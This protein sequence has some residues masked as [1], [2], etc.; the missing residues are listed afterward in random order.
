MQLHRFGRLWGV[1]TIRHWKVLVFM[2]KELLWRE[3][4]DNRKSIE[5]IARCSFLEEEI[6]TLVMTLHLDVDATMAGVVAS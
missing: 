5:G 4:E 2:V 6:L 3:K 1:G